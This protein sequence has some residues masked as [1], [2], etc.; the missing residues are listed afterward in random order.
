M[1]TKIN[2]V[3]KEIGQLRK[4]GGHMSHDGRGL[5]LTYGVCLVQTRRYQAD[6]REDKLREREEDERRPRYRKGEGTRP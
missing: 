4:V 6:G 5:D 3:Q 1:G 2:A